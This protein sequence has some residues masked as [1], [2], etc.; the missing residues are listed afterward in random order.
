MEFIAVW[1]EE[2]II[3]ECKQF[4][5]EKL[6]FN[7]NNASEISND[8][9]DL[10]N[11]S[12][13]KDLLEYRKQNTEMCNMILV[14]LVVIILKLFFYFLAFFNLNFKSVE[15]FS[16]ASLQFEIPKA[17]MEETLLFTNLNRIKLILEKKNFFFWKNN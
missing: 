10:P 8:L 12:F 7:S 3:D 17:F 4:H 15:F 1:Y 13:L 14:L 5:Q 11:V 2:I 6:K 16:K 9:L